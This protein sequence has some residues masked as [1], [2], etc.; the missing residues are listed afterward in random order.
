[1]SGP[2]KERQSH[3]KS[4]EATVNR[5]ILTVLL[6]TLGRALVPCALPQFGDPGRV[7]VV[8]VRLAHLVLHE[9]IV[10]AIAGLRSTH[11]AALAG[12]C[13]GAQAH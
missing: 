3:A 2:Q 12:T 1:M 6:G 4:V 9:R 13:R 11:G 10:L 7:R 5:K 8:E